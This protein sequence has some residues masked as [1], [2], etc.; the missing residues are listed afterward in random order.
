VSGTVPGS[1][2]SVPEPEPRSELDRTTGRLSLFMLGWGVAA[3]SALALVGGGRD[4][5]V[6]TAGVA[7][8]IF[9]LRSLRAQVSQLDARVPRSG[10]VAAFRAL[11]RFAA[12][13]LLLLA[14]FELGSGHALAAALGAASLPCALL[15]ETALQALRQRP[16]ASRT[17]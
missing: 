15:V 1:G 7:A 8:S 3:G 11:G 14:L 6:L 4:L 5:L 12:L 10:G 16:R 9:L 17:S 2:L 13:A